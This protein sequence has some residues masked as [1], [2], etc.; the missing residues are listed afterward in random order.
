MTLCPSSIPLGVV[1]PSPPGSSLPAGADP[2]SYLARASSSSLV[3]FA[4][5]YRLDYCASLVSDLDP[6]CPPSVEGEVALSCDVL[7][8]RQE[9]LEYLAASAPHLATMLLALEGNPDALDIPTPRSYREAISG[10]YV[11]EVPPPGANI[12]S[13]MWIFRVK[14]PPSSPPALKAPQRD[15]KLHSLDFSTAFLQGSLYEA[16]LRRPL[17]GLRQAPC[18]WLNTLRTTLAALGY[19]PSTA[20]PSLFLRTDTTL[21]LFYILVCVDDLVFATADT[22]A[23][24]LVKAE[25][26]E[27]HTYT[28]LGPSAFQL[29][30]LLVIAYSSVYR[31]LA[32]SSTFGQVLHQAWGSCL[33]DGVQ[34]Y[35]VEIYAGAMAAKELRWLTYLL[36]D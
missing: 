27:R 8:D 19:A 18:E 30:V 34:C 5:A 13:G 21:P 4:V 33:E 12:V 11:D 10:T 3:D 36:T 15:Y 17:Y 29:P 28:D 2:P 26:Q 22:E 24:A 16:I 7:E 6:A 9:E 31:P 14:R 20:D 35:E 23:L 25:L 1:L 32:L